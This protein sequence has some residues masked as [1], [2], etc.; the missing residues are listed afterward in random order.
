MV[1][2]RHTA[3]AS[4]SLQ[5]PQDSIVNDE[6]QECSSAKKIK[7]SDTDLGFVP[8]DDCNFFY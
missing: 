6:H 7:L 2:N 3:K 5:L 4:T 1:I 8:E